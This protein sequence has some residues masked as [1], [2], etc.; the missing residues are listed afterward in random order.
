MFNWQDVPVAEGGHSNNSAWLPPRD[1][2]QDI[3]DATDSAPWSFLSE[4]VLREEGG[5]P[6]GSASCLFPPDG[7]QDVAREEDD[8]STGRA[9][10]VSPRDMTKNFCNECN[11]GFGRK[12]ELTRHLKQTR[13]HG[14]PKKKCRLC[15]K[16]LSRG[17]T[18]KD[19]ESKCSGK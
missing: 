14:G 15:G 11:K 5:D 2:T 16:L 18:L 10:S 7:T 4:D 8:D 1:V 9:P 17:H 19:H 3:S 6:T 12:S 13:K